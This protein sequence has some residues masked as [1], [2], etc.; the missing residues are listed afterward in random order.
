MPN[1][2]A[3]KLATYRRTAHATFPGGSAL[4][5]GRPIPLVRIAA[6]VGVSKGMIAALENGTKQPG[7]D[8]AV[9]LQRLG[10]AEPAD[11]R[12]DVCEAA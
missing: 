6:A 7:L 3:S 9:R 5:R 11:W 12:A 10:V 1:V 2:G 4:P 8:L